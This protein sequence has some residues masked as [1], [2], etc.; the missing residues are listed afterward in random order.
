[1]RT[2]SD[3]PGIVCGLYTNFIQI[4]EC[5]PSQYQCFILFFN[6][7]TMFFDMKMDLQEVGLGGGGA[8]TGLI[9]LRIGTGGELL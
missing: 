3:L 6:L 1:M 8:W 5:G 2:A 7:K 4:I 9:W